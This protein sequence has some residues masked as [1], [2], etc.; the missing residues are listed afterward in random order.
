MHKRFFCITDRSLIIVE[1]RLPPVKKMAVY[2]TCDDFN[3]AKS[4]W[5]MLDPNNPSSI[6][7]YL[8]V[9]IGRNYLPFEGL[10][11]IFDSN[12]MLLTK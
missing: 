8:S 2:L 12:N 6:N 11:V 7:K 3:Y 4:K 1:L 10:S 5:L 9:E